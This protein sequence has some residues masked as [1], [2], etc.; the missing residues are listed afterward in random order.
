[1]GDVERHPNVA[2]ELTRRAEARVG[3]VVRGRWRLDTLLGVGGM[4]AVYAA[5][6]RNGK[7]VALKILHSEVSTNAEIR[8]RFVDEGYAANRVGHPGAVSVID[9]DIAEDGCA[10]LV[11]D[12]LEGETLEARMQ[13]RGRMWPGELLPIVD[14]LLDVLAAAHDHGIVHRDIKPDNIFITSE[15]SVK[16]LDFG[17]A[18]LAEPGRPR[19]TLAGT[20][21][22]TPPFMAPE[23]A[24]GHWESLD[25]RTDLWAVGATM[26][27]QLTGRQ[28]HEGETSN[29]ELLLAM[30]RPAPSIGSIAP[31][32]PKAI[33]DLVD[34]ALAFAQEDRWPTARDMQAACRTVLALL[35]PEAYAP[36]G[37]DASSLSAAESSLSVAFLT[38]RRRVSRVFGPPGGLRGKL[39]LG[40]AGGV[41]TV[42]ALMILDRPERPTSVSH[43]AGVPSVDIP[44]PTENIASSSEPLQPDVPPSALVAAPEPESVASAREAW[45]PSPSKVER[46]QPLKLA[47]RPEAEDPRSEA[48]AP[49]ST[50]VVAATAALPVGAPAAAEEPPS[51]VDPLERRK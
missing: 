18:R 1:M 7:R 51:G 34:R 2:D 35:G 17:I 11:M 12:L 30:T 10:F 5:T 14:G 33:V 13:R 42:A 23:Q 50:P 27:F 45:V 39:L 41:M 4:A 31:N 8:R 15:R 3:Q 44:L 24:R 49:P 36:S 40:A 47:P 21:M 37:D 32:L 16:L 28:V 19:T 22:G 25:G 38:P 43:V 29:E 48:S 20:P 26:F 46:P 6:H 9:D